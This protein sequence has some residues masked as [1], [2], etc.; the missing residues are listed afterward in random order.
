[1][2]LCPQTPF[3]DDD[4]GI[5]ISMRAERPECAHVLLLLLLPLLLLHAVYVVRL[6][7]ERPESAHGHVTCSRGNRSND[8]S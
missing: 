8:S 6:R 2:G 4:R 1:M 7:A 5:L 3:D